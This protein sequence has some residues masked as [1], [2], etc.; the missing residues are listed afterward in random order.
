MGNAEHT[1]DC[2]DGT[3]DTGADDASDRTVFRAGNTIAFIGAFL[4]AAH[5]ALGMPRLWHTGQGG[6]NS[7]ASE[8]QTE[9]Q[10]GR[11]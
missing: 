4:S 10:T 3:A 9:R 11:P 7:G 6:Q 2:A 8:E 1:L 5:D